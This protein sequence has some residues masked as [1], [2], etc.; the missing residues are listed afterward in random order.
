MGPKV[1][2]GQVWTDYDTRRLGVRELE[3][4]AIVGT[5]VTVLD[6]KTKRSRQVKLLRFGKKG[7]GYK[8]V[9]DGAVTSSQPSAVSQ[10]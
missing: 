3:V 9:R 8:F 1:Q 4:K 5:T 7:N 2:V 10:R 6:L